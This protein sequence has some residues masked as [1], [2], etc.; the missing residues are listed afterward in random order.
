MNKGLKITGTILLAISI[1]YGTYYFF[2]YFIEA[3]GYALRDSIGFSLLAE[4]L[5][6]LILM[7]AILMVVGIWTLKPVFR[8]ISLIVYMGALGIFLIYRMYNLIVFPG[9]L[10]ALS[11][12]LTF[13]EII[14][15][16]IGILLLISIRNCRKGMVIAISILIGVFTI[17]VLAMIATGSKPY[18]VLLGEMPI[19]LSILFANILSTARSF[20]PTASYF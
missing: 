6:Q 9:G 17:I 2:R 11:K 3:V 1:L 16:A 8:I 7:C 12:V 4:S 19:I 18:Y 10:N 14:E 15:V 20:R 13:R 5:D